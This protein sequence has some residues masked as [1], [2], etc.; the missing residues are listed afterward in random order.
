MV[1][2]PEVQRQLDAT[3]VV[4]DHLEVG[5]GGDYVALTTNAHFHGNSL[6]QISFPDTT[7]DSEEL[8]VF[9]ASSGGNVQRY[10]SWCAGALILNLGDISDWECALAAGQTAAPSMSMY[11]HHIN[12]MTF[13]FGK[14]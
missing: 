2:L 11:D 10:R 4:V 3:S 13:L 14:K 1:S 12:S 9:D 8:R 6:P 7:I 5:A